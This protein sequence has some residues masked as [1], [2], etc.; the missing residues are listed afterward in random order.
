MF[1]LTIVSTNIFE[2][3][4]ESKPI[5]VYD[6]NLIVSKMQVGQFIRFQIWSHPVNIDGIDHHPLIEESYLKHSEEF[7]FFDFIPQALAMN[8]K[9]KKINKKIMKA[10]MDYLFE[11]TEERQRI[12]KKE[13]TSK[14]NVKIVVS[15]KYLVFL[16]FGIL[17]LTGGYYLSQTTL[18][19]VNE[20]VSEKTDAFEKELEL[21]SEKEIGQ[22]Y[23][24]KWNEIID[25]YVENQLFEKL[26]RFHSYYQTAK[27]E[28]ELAFYHEEWERVISSEMTLSNERYSVML[29]HALIQLNQLEE[30]ELVN[31]QLHSEILQGALNQAYF[32]QAM[33]HLREKEIENAQ[34]AS[35]KIKDQS[36]VMILEQQI[37]HV[38]IIIQLI[39]FYSENNDADNQAIW[40]RKL[41]MIGK[42]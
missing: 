38:A 42:E 25:Y 32:N 40:E 30:A 35:Q 31:Q 22:L 16:S 6:F 33:D 21:L 8:V 19:S 10:M 5:G 11:A 27:G 7:G 1:K 15:K 26:D 36:M 4:K 24:E 12:V 23:P 17:L 37:D 41:A 20:V 28:A 34:K 9:K 2:L 29:V 14:Q 13:K 3:E 39:Q 18:F